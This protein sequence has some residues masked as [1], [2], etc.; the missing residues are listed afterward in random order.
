M[1]ILVFLCIQIFSL[2][3]LCPGEVQKK[4]RLVPQHVFHSYILARLSFLLL[5][6]R[7]S[8]KREHRGNEGGKQ[9]VK[10]G[11]EQNQED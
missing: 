9:G 5:S 2:P 6:L 10:D 8:L 7:T 4:P 11:Y 1:N 3:H